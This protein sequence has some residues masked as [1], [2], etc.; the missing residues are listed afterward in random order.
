VRL[1]DYLL[2]CTLEY[3]YL[4]TYVLTPISV[5]GLRQLSSR[6]AVKRALLNTSNQ[7]TNK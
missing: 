5:A 2:I 7:I 1:F 6:T 3:P 4:L